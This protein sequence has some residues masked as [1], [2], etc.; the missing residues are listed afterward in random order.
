MEISVLRQI[1]VNANVNSYSKNKMERITNRWR[2]KKRMKCW[3]RFLLAAWRVQLSWIYQMEKILM[4]KK[5]IWKQ[6]KWLNFNYTIFFSSYL[7]KNVRDVNWS[8]ETMSTEYEEWKKKQEV[9]RKINQ[10]CLSPELEGSHWT[11][12]E[13]G[14]TGLKW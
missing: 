10:E 1:Q 14:G 4:N 6:P 11:R 8:L 13:E 5:I 9:L 12:R 2:S 7:D 3:L